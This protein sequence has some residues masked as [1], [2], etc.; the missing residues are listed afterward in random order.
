VPWRR[1][2]RRYYRSEVRDLLGIAYQEEGNSLN[3]LQ[4]PAQ[5]RV[6]G[7]AL[8]LV[9]HC[10]IGLERVGY[11]LPS[12]LTERIQRC[13]DQKQPIEIITLSN[14]P[15]LIWFTQ[16]VPIGHRLTRLDLLHP[17]TQQLRPSDP[18]LLSPGRDP[19]A[20]P[21]P[22]LNIY[23][24]NLQAVGFNSSDIT[25]LA[26]TYHRDRPVINCQPTHR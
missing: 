17:P 22:T 12:K 25:H 23:F 2:V 7:G 20:S 18:G 8:L 4:H 14:C 1:F 19:N 21:E 13:A 3:P 15:R 24:V 6:L 11:G 5:G 16:C 10:F 26:R 9:K